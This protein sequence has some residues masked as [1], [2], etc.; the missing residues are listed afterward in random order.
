MGGR[1]ASSGKGGGGRGASSGKGKGEIVQF[2]GKSKSMVDNEKGWEYPGFSQKYEQ[3]SSALDK[4]NSL[5]RIASI[6]KAAKDQDKLIT[7]EIE[8]LHN[9]TADVMGSENALLSNRRKMRTLIMKAKN[10]AR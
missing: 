8:R 2:P 4:T 7:K 6:V 3:L 9:G 5:N 1:G 10:K